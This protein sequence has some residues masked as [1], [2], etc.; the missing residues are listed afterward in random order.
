MRGE[1]N[2]FLEQREKEKFPGAVLSADAVAYARTTSSVWMVRKRA[3]LEFDGLEE[4]AKKSNNLK[5]EVAMKK[6]P[7]GVPVLLN[8]FRLIFIEVVSKD[9]LESIPFESIFC[10][11][12]SFK[13]IQFILRSVN[14][15]EKID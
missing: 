13:V 12:L 15:N 6:Y 10:G 11:Y 5:R 7:T 9:A 1:N 3:S 14:I 8:S 4:N 2:R